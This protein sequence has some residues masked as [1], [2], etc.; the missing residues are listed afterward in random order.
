MCSGILKKGPFI[1]LFCLSRSMDQKE[2]TWLHFWFLVTSS[3]PHLLISR[4]RLHVLLKQQN[5]PM[6]GNRLK[7]TV[8]PSRA[9]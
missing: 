1:L 5:L 3:V 8:K 4:W 9:V 7:E 2:T 6:S